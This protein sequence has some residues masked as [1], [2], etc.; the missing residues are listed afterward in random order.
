ML[1]VNYGV[2]M[3]LI[4]TANGFE[5]QYPD[6]FVA[7]TLNMNPQTPVYASN[8][9]TLKMTRVECEKD[10]WDIP[11]FVGATDRGHLWSEEDGR[12]F[13]RISDI[14][15]TFVWIYLSPLHYDVRTSGRQSESSFRLDRA[16][17]YDRLG[18]LEGP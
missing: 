4:I 17:Y 1:G 2:E 16:D 5:Y 9:Y 7:G 15:P 10:D 6:C 12:S 14:Y 13:V 11:T 8:S 3:T 18:G